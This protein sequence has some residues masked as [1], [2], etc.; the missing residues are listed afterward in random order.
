MKKLLFLVMAV[1]LVAFAVPAL[2]DNWIDGGGGAVNNNMVG[3]TA[4]DDSVNKGSV[5]SL[6]VAG[7]YN[8]G[9]QNVI[10]SNN[11]VTDEDFTVKGYGEFVSDSTTNSTTFS[12]NNAQIGIAATGSLNNNNVYV[13]NMDTAWQN[14]Y[15]YTHQ[16]D[17]QLDFSLT[18]EAAAGVTPY[19]PISNVHL[20]QSNTGIKTGDGA[21]AVGST[22]VGV[23][24]NFGPGSNV[25]GMV[26][27][28][29]NL[30]GVAQNQAGAN[31]VSAFSAAP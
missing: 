30:G 19:M 5:D 25:S 14:Q 11:I 23:Q 7:T 8:L 6:A 2:A 27:V 18:F 22:A 13:G 9:S 20:A 1:A 17:H 12:G 3:S 10:G 26:G 21:G 4:T 28:S 15:Q 24:A 31:V 29:Q 16:Y